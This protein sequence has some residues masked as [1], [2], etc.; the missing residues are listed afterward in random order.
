MRRRTF[1]RLRFLPPV[2]IRGIGIGRKRGGAICAS[3]RVT[4]CKTTT[5][6]REPMHYLLFYEKVNDYAERE[7]PM[8]SAHRMHVEAAV[9]RGELVLGG[10]LIDPA[11]GANVLLF[12][13]DTAA[14]AESFAKSDPYV[15]NGIVTRWHVRAWQT[16]VGPDAASPLPE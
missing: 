1:R 13:A 6:D 3:I 11:D 7:G 4:A 14:T 16:V 2:S 15:K 8:R 9:S 5:P 10:P 12:R